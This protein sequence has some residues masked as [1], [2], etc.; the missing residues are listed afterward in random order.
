[1]SLLTRGNRWLNDRFSEREG[2]SVTYLRDAESA[3]VA[4]VVA[5]RT[6]ATRQGFG[7]GQSAASVA[8]EWGDRDFL[9]PV[10]NLVLSG[11][12]TQPRQ[13]DR[14][15]S[16]QGTFK[17]IVPA[18]EPPWRFSDVEETLYRVH[19]KRVPT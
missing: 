8:V 5:G 7:P 18:G 16:P 3:E 15:V 19:T 13:G 4:G 11:S 17:I 14:I 1:M 6:L 12:A 2:T 10:A 9:I